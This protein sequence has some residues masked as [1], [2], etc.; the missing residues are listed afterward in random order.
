MTGIEECG[1]AIDTESQVNAFHWG[2]KD[3]QITCNVRKR[4]E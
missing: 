1:P 4:I 3:S 2:K